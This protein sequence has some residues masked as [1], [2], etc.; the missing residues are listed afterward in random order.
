HYPTLNKELDSAAFPN[1]FK[2][3]EM[4]GTLLQVRNC[5]DFRP[6][7]AKHLTVDLRTIEDTEQDQFFEWTNSVFGSS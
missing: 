3:I 6:G 1:S 2:N 7:S 4:I 5:Y